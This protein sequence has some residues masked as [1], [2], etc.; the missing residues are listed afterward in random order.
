MQ[1]TASD[2]HPQD[3]AAAAAAAAAPGR[4]HVQQRQGEQWQLTWGE[5]RRGHLAFHDGTA[6]QAAPADQVLQRGSGH[7]GRRA[8]GWAGRRAAGKSVQHT[9][10][11]AGN[12]KCSGHAAASGLQGVPKHCH[13]GA[14][15]TAPQ[16]A[17]GTNNNSSSPKAHLGKDLRQDVLDVGSVDLQKGQKE[18]KVGTCCQASGERLRTRQSASCCGWA[19]Q[20]LC[21]GQCTARQPVQ[22]Q[23]TPPWQCPAAM[24]GR[25]THPPC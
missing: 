1:R 11:Q 8:G 4:F 22:E 3:A 15:C 24:L 12:Q 10:Q 21:H 14:R 20:P 6:E 17:W 13:V 23:P 25:D 9:Q 18:A 2:E 5:G 16:L 7:V 19:V